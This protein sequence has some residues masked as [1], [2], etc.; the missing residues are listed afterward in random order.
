MDG[1]MDG[2]V[3][4]SMRDVIGWHASVSMSCLSAG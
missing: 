3:D 1:W 4:C 2:W